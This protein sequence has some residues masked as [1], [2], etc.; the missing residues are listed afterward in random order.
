MLV[1]GLVALVFLGLDGWMVWLGAT[2]GGLNVAS[3]EES[4]AVESLSGADDIPSIP[5]DLTVRLTSDGGF[6]MCFRYSTNNLISEE[7]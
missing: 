5:W 6:N 7:N 1:F 3:S 4:R 2:F